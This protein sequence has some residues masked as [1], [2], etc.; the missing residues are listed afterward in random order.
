MVSNIVNI[1]VS[2]SSSVME[3]LTL[4]VGLDPVTFV[5][6]AAFVGFV[7]VLSAS[8]SLIAFVTVATVAD[9]SAT[10]TSTLIDAVASVV[11]VG[12]ITVLVDELSVVVV[13]ES[14][15]LVSLVSS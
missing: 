4:V 9:D 15:L 10:I 5:G 14:V 1:S 2:Y 11:L 7:T 12:S 13:D 6:T 8:G 3:Q